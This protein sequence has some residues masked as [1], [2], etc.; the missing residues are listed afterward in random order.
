MSIISRRFDR[1]GNVIRLRDE[2]L[3]SIRHRFNF[4]LK[5]GISDFVQLTLGLAHSSNVV[6][7]QTRYVFPL[8][9]E[10]VVVLNVTREYTGVEDLYAGVDLRAPL[11][12]R[13]VDVAVTLGVS[14]PLAAFEPP[15]PDHSFETVQDESGNTNRFNYHYTYPTGRGVTVAH[16]GGIVKYRLAKWAFSARVDYRH[17]M[18]DGSNYE[19]RHQMNEE[20]DFE[21]R[22]DPFTYRLPDSFSYRAEAEYQPLPW[23]NLFADVSMLTSYRGW[24]ARF[25]DVRVGTAEDLFVSIDPGFEIIITPRLWLRERLS[26]ALAGESHEAPFAFQTTLMY[27][28]F[29]F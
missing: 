2:G 28:F 7:E 9:P 12:T 15:E 8:P 23:F 1:D 24:T 5:Y 3:S 16:L 20:G 22:K 10:P 4:D 18:D 14:L 11:N 29:P 26:F 13:K 6:R 27:N 19:W 21:Y 25:E 17:G